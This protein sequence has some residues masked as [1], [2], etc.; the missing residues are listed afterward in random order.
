MLESIQPHPGRLR[1][2]DEL[3]LLDE[4]LASSD[5]V[6]TLIRGLPDLLAVRYALAV[7]VAAPELVVATSAGAPDTDVLCDWIPLTES[8]RLQPKSNK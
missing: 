6:Q 4:A 1:V 8:G 3:A 5:P 7:D 2:H